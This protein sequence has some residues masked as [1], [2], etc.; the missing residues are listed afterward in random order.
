MDEISVSKA[1]QLSHQPEEP[2]KT[3][4]CI[5]AGARFFAA[6]HIEGGADAYDYRHIPAPE[7][8]R[9]SEFLARRRQS[10]QEDV[11]LRRRYRL[12]DARSSSA[13]NSRAV[14]V[15]PSYVEAG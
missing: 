12:I 10:H 13:E 7:R 2:L 1:S 6:Q 8:S 11:R 14:G 9:D 5:Q 15:G 3:L 4:C